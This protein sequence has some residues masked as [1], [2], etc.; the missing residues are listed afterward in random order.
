ME[1]MGNKIKI[2]KPIGFISVLIIFSGI[3][4][5]CYS[6]DV[7]PEMKNIYGQSVKPKSL[8]DEEL[9]KF[10][11]SVR[12]IDGEAEAHYKMALYFQERRRHKLAIDELKQVLK[13]DPANTKAY[14]AIGISFDELGDNDIAVGYYKMALQIDPKLDYVYNNLGYSYLLK[15]DMQDAVES[16]Q[17]A[18][19]LNEKEKRYSNN[20]GLAYAKQGKYELAYDQFK[21]LD[22]DANAEKMLA[23]VLKELGKEAEVESALLAVRNTPKTEA[24]VAKEGDSPGIPVQS[25]LPGLQE[26]NNTND[27]VAEVKPEVPKEVVAEVKPEAPK[28]AVA[29]FKPGAPKNVVAEVKPDIP[30]DAVAEVKIDENPKNAVIDVTPA[31]PAPQNPEEIQIAAVQPLNKQTVDKAGIKEDAKFD[32]VSA[33]AALRSSESENPAPRAG[34][35]QV[36]NIKILYAAS[37]SQTGGSKAS[38]GMAALNEIMIAVENG[39]GVKGAARKVAEQL[40]RKGFKV[41]KVSDARS[42]DHFSTKVFY[43]FDNLKEVQR[44]LRVIPESPKSA[45]LFKM[46]NMGP[47]PIRLLIG[48]DMVKKETILAHGTKQEALKTASTANMSRSSNPKKKKA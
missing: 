3:I 39:N 20:L 22:S 8:T 17:Q 32:T 9:R 34:T 24:V 40:R 18:I 36:Q 46:E 30:K 4:Y 1:H 48:K 25:V 10:A 28:D 15:N 43:E 19:A 47:P 37:S 11:G 6:R 5:G 14:N 29:E 12:R 13:R 23:R 26:P 31:V 42:F 7:A 35:I 33:S 27:A 16:F 38:H 2:N 44:L 45:E 21:A 41:V